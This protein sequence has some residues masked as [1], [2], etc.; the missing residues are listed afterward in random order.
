MKKSLACLLVLALALPA[1]AT[2]PPAHG[3][4]DQ[5][6]LY[7]DWTSFTPTGT[8][9][10]N[11]TYAG[12]VRQVGDTIWVQYALTF[13][14]APNSVTATL[15]P[16]SGFTVDESKLVANETAI[17]AWWAGDTGTSVRGT[18]IAVYNKTTDVID[19]KDC[20]TAPNTVLNAT[21]AVPFSFGNTDTIDVFLRLPTSTGSPVAGKAF[22]CG[23]AYV[24]YIPTRSFTETGVWATNT[25]YTAMVRLVG[26]TIE[27]QCYANLSGA[28]TGSQALDVPTGYTLDETR[29]AAS[30]NNQPIVGS[31]APAIRG[32]GM[33]RCSLGGATHPVTQFVR[34]TAPNTYT[35]VSA[36]VPVTFASGDNVGVSF[37]LPVSAVPSWSVSLGCGAQLS[38]EP[39]TS[40][41]PTGTWTGNTTYSGYWSRVG[42]VVYLQE[43]C[44]TAGAPSPSATALLFDTPAGGNPLTPSASK[45][46]TDSGSTA[47]TECSQIGYTWDS[48]ANSY[49]G[50]FWTRCTAVSARDSSLYSGTAPNTQNGPTNAQPF[51]YASGDTLSEWSWYPIAGP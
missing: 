32:P 48:S 4:G 30:S 49:R 7:S 22:G 8:F 12:R 5:L 6:R 44:T 50:N 41:T 38:Y 26:D 20:T 16:P 40:Y 25:T 10:T 46:P 9:T 35:Q 13:A 24:P 15:N 42:D 51:T 37:W 1:L 17:G 31:C 27:V 14:G 28:P 18:G 45:M 43:F 34:T 11:T 47:R 33:C 36:T 29:F 21:Q 19:L 3:C 39:W 23:A 2:N